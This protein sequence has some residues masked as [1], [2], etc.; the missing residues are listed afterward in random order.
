MKNVFIAVGGSGAKVAEALVRLLAIGFPTRKA[1]GVYTSHGDS[2]QIWRIDPDRSSGAAVALQS[3]VTEY[4]QLQ[5]YLSNGGDQQ[6]KLGSHWAMDLD[7]SVRHLDPLQLPQ[8]TP[9]D[10]EIKTLRG[11]L[12]SRYG[13]RKSSDPLL[14]PFYTD[15]EL[16]VRID[17]GFYQKPFI[18]APIMAI[19]ADSLNDE[20]SPGGREAGL[21]AFNNNATNFFLCGSLHGGTG[22][23]G[24]PVMGKFLGERKRQNPHWGW[25]IGGCLLSPYSVPPQPPFKALREGERVA[26]Q[27]VN[28]LLNRH[29]NDPAFKELTVEEKKDLVYQILRG[30]YADP[31]DMEARARQGLTYYKAHS[32]NYFD[33]LYL[34]GKP[35]PDKLKVWSNGGSS[36]RNPLNSAEVVAALAALNYF[37]G[38]GAGDRQSYIIGASTADMQSERMKLSE[39]PKY[40]L[41]RGGEEVDPEKVFL[42][43]AVLRHLILHQIPW[44][45]RAVNWDKSIAGL[46]SYYQNNEQ[47]KEEDL[48]F[49]R[50]V[51][52]ALISN[53]GALLDPGQT[54]GWSGDDFREL[55]SYLSD[56][57]AD[58]R[59]I[60]AKT[61]KKLFSLEAK[62]S[63]STGLSSIKV[64]AIEFGGWCPQG[65]HF[66]RGEYLRG[67]WSRLFE[68]AQDKQ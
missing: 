26:E 28:A 8:A 45:D 50:R 5:G 47:K 13:G 34:V 21:T 14:E 62:E 49:Y 6:H 4:A 37:A 1:A 63:L 53:I 35:E 17:R 41:G 9:S 18:G 38:S 51:A 29:S 61:A 31:S 65:D 52:D 54:I 7:P 46:R 22:A 58:V 30:F 27:D 43:T 20:N 64:S 56:A 36:Q 32:A 67:V 39:L 68:R 24:V 25:R 3:C 42:S 59:E 10:N 2:L 33:E 66:S 60:T 15:D 16:D 48:A 55:S 23:C 40:R 12:D 11:I 44:G 19:F 57:E